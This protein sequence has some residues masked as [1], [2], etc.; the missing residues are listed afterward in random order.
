MDFRGSITE[1][2][3]TAIFSLERSDQMEKQREE[4]D[5]LQAV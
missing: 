1:V 3:V 4:D 2:E 5:T